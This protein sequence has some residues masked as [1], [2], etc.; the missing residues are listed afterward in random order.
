[1]KIP[2]EQFRKNLT[3]QYRV[4]DDKENTKEVQIPAFDLK[5]VEGNVLKVGD[6]VAAAVTVY[7]SADLRVVKIKHFIEIPQKVFHTDDWYDEAK[8]AQCDA[9][10]Y[11][12]KFEDAKFTR[13]EKN[14][15]KVA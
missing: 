1:M 2:V 14:V 6:K 3:A 5:D 11:E 7:R 12:I 8:H 10:R 9:V 15:V 4:M 13:D